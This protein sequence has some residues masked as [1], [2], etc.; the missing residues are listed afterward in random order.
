MLAA[1]TGMA[2]GCQWD[3]LVWT[4]SLAVRVVWLRTIPV[5]VEMVKEP[6]G[7]GGEVSDC[8]RVIKKNNYFLEYEM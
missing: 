1:D 4:G 2:L 5:P 3:D 7:N 6:Y 8:Y